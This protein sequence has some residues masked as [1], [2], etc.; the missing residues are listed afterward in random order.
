MDASLPQRLKS[1][2]KSRAYVSKIILYGEADAHAP[3]TSSLIAS[4][5]QLL[6]AETV[7]NRLIYTLHGGLRSFSHRYSY[8][9]LPSPPLDAN[10]ILIPVCLSS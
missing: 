2:W 4:I 9:C 10:G 3:E 7:T 1:R 6:R 8:L 5:T